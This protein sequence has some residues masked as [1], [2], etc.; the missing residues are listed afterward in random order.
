M[1]DK[2]NS[3]A[4]PKLSFAHSP[5]SSPPLLSSPANDS[6]VRPED[7]EKVPLKSKIKNILTRFFKG[8]TPKQ[9]LERR[10]ILKDPAQ[11]A[12]EQRRKLQTRKELQ[13]RL[14]TRLSRSTLQH[15][16]ILEPEPQSPESAA[17][18]SNTT[19]SST[20]SPHQ[21]PMPWYYGTNMKRR[22]K[23]TA[24]QIRQF[25][26]KRG[27]GTGNNV[28][29]CS[30]SEQTAQSSSR[31]SKKKR[32]LRQAPA[33][34][35]TLRG[36]RQRSVS[37]PDLHSYLQ[38]AGVNMKE[39]EKRDDNTQFGV[40]LEHVALRSATVALPH[41]TQSVQVRVPCLVD[42][43][44]QYLQTGE[45]LKTEGLFRV[46]GD[47][48]NIDRLRAEWAATMQST[49]G[50]VATSSV[51]ASAS[52]TSVSSSS[53]GPMTATAP[54]LL[55]QRCDNIHTVCGLLK[56]F[57][58]ELPEPVLTFERYSAF[59]HAVE[60]AGLS[61][62]CTP[63]A[64]ICT[65][66]TS[67]SPSVLP[68]NASSSSSPVAT[69]PSTTAPTVPLDETLST[70]ANLIS[71]LPTLHQHLL[72]YLM[73]FLLQV[74]LKSAFN[75]MDIRNVSSGKKPCSTSNQSKSKSFNAKRDKIN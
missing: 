47:Y 7:K 51:S 16:G 70:V 3:P 50:T 8:R 39:T 28:S 31:K 6:D 29:N 27:G 30:S 74:T 14:S 15:I 58:R 59:T 38:K 37:M 18:Y 45:R 75:R 43:C 33:A 49:P 72:L 71:D 54:S 61:V 67:N 42:E 13:N 48:A 20:L 21:K 5:S 22:L 52:T 4:S 56:A 41:Q 66:L 23:R 32:I 17:D 19:L 24:S 35:A 2:N 9:D 53:S 69:T 68:S 25:K 10:N 40:A 44:V 1:N 34:G 36:V 26:L 55:I 73:S 63:S 64:S 11:A 57:L 12:E 60:S 65:V 46:S 62:E